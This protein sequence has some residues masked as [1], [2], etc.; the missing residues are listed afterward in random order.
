[1]NLVPLKNKID[2]YLAKIFFIRFIQVLSGFSLIIFFVNFLEALDKAADSEISLWII[3]LMGFLRI[4]DFLNDIISSLILFAGIATFFFLAIKSEIT[5]IRSCGYSLLHIITPIAYC[6]F[7]LGLFWIF[8]FSPISILM[9]KKFNALER[10]YIKKEYREVIESNS[11]IWIKQPNQ[12]K[13]NEEIIIQAKKVYKENVELSGVSIWFFDDK[14]Q[15]YRRIDAKSMILQDGFWQ[16]KDLID[17]NQED[18]NKF[19]ENYILPTK[20]EKKFIIDKVVSN[21]QNV[22]LFS[23]F[24]L[25]SL[26]SDLTEAGF[27]SA[28]FRVY[29]NSLLTK[30]ILFVAMILIS[31]FFGINN[32]RNNN[33]LII[34]MG[35]IF[36]LILYI[37]LSFTAALG[38][39]RFIPVFASTWVITFICLS[40]GTILTYKKENL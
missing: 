19:S 12:D 6:A 7:A 34:F 35:M 40:L 38:S 18:L 20:L 39:S 8:C 26:I 10:E 33:A 27:Q 32:H 22:K 5:I 9:T 29:Y 2:R 37:I 28:K 1:M 3:I 25:P 17:N 15:F 11:G 16:I 21:F 24:K 4:P 31:C 30:P 13:E 36:G 14:M 23:I